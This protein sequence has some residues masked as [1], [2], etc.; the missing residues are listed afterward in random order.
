MTVETLASVA[1]MSAPIVAIVFVVVLG[2]LSCRA[3]I[4]ALGF[5]LKRHV[6]RWL[7]LS[8][9]ASLVV[10]AVCVIARFKLIG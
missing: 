2:L 10:F 6:L 4:A 7:D 5:T 8:I 1:T 3:G 9:A